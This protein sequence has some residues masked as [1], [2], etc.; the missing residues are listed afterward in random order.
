MN[1]QNKSVKS[2]V[3]TTVTLSTKQQTV[4]S[5]HTALPMRKHSTARVSLIKRSF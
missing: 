1:E 3:K 5:P 4:T 2:I